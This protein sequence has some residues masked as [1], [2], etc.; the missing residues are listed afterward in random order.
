MAIFNF[1]QFRTAIGTAL[2]LGAL[3]SVTG[4]SSMERHVEY[5]TIKPEQYPVISAIGYAPVAAQHGETEQARILLA[6]RASRLEAYRELAEQVQGTYLSGETKVSDMVV[7]NDSFRS[8][9]SGLIRGAEVV[10]SYPVGDYYATELKID[11]ERLQN[12]YISTTR[13]TKLKS[14]HYY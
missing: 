11:F 1:K 10:R 2:V 5:Q 4:C 9:V 14:I 8:E 6:M 7:Q 3:S 12:V 13:P